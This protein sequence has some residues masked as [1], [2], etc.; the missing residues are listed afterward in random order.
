MSPSEQ[1]IGILRVSGPDSRGIVAAFSQLLFGHGCGI[2]ESEQSIDRQVNKFFQRIKFD[3]ST[4]HTDR[5]TLEAG[6]KEVCNRFNME[7]SLNWGDKK[8]KIAI[9]VSKYDHVL[10][11]I[12]LRHEA[13]ELDCDISVIISNHPDLKHIADTF[14]IPFEVFK[15]NKENKAEQEKKELDLLQNTY[16][17]DLVILARYMQIISDDF[18]RAFDHKVINIHHSFLPAFI[19]GKPYHRAHE[20]GV[21]LIGA[22]AHYATADLDEGPIIEQVSVVVSISRCTTSRSSSNLNL[23]NHIYFLYEKCVHRILHEFLIVSKLR[24]FFER[25]DFSRKMS[26]FML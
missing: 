1:K 17:V 16:N 12:L 4:L 11:E 14:K 26:W 10:W 3:Y 20:R 7:T 6:V 13:G 25:V 9:M 8:K 5:I 15:I 21:K 19:G 2:E 23:T 18:C 22:T 24:I